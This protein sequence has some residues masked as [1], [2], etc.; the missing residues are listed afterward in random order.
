MI[1]KLCSLFTMLCFVSALFAA[2]KSEADALYMKE[3]Y[4]EAA[5]AYEGILKEG[6]AS[7]IYYNLGNCYYKMDNF[8]R[9]ILNYERALQM[10][11]GDSDTRSNLALARGK[12]I[13][14]VIPPSEMFFVTWWRNLTNIMSLGSW[15]MVGIVSFVL[16]L[17]G[18]CAYMLMSNLLVRKI[19]VYGAMAMFVLCVVANFAALTQNIN[20]QQRDGAIVM[21]AAVTVKS[22]PSERSTDLF[23]IHEG[24]KVTILDS[25]MKD[26]MEVKYEEGKQGWI[27]VSDIEII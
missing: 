7:E 25:T 10:S 12:T 23:V 16:M 14:K 26:W 19:G 17:C 6:V 13:D 11:P 3:K 8:P 27:R 20:V 24:S 15:S 1:K 2:T 21:S 22:S 18:I 9:A 4:A 5:K